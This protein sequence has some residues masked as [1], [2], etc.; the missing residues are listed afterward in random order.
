M[1][2]G[3]TTNVQLAQ[4]PCLTHR[5]QGVPRET[6]ERK[7]QVEVVTLHVVT[8]TPRRRALSDSYEHKL[9]RSVSALGFSG[10]GSRQSAVPAAEHC[11]GHHPDKHA[12]HLAERNKRKCDVAPNPPHSNRPD[13]PINYDAKVFID[14]EWHGWVIPMGMF[15]GSFV[16]GTKVT[17]TS[18]TLVP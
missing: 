6:R 5:M 14:E 13:P 4:E 2:E 18:S 9:T 1:I 11:A 16:A 17:T 12:E 7:G 15:D 3:G 8:D 10:S